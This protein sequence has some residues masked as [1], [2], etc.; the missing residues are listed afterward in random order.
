MIAETTTMPNG[1]VVFRVVQAPALDRASRGD[2]DVKPSPRL[3]PDVVQLTVDSTHG[4]Y[5]Q[6]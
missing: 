4:R 6:L 3:K 1:S 2:T 5:V